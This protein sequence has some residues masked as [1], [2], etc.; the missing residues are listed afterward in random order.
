VVLP[1]PQPQQGAR[2]TKLNEVNVVLHTLKGHC[3]EL[4]NENPLR[5]HHWRQE[6]QEMPQ[7][8]LADGD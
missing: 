2:Q 8:T 5:I 6:E 1:L 3:G 4:K 7:S